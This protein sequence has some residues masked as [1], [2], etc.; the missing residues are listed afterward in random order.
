MAWLRHCWQ[1]GAIIP[2]AS[3]ETVNE[4]IRVLAYPK[5]KLTKEERALIL[6]DF[7]PYAETVVIADVP[8]GL[9]IIRNKA[10]QMFLILTVVGQAET[11][12]TGNVIIEATPKSYKV[13]TIEHITF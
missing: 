12:V 8:E 13:Y 9:P 1:T 7:L 11:L 2:L 10:D 4:L 6:A 3:K 5:F